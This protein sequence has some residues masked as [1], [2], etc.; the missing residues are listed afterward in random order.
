MKKMNICS[1]TRHGIHKVSSIFVNYQRMSKNVSFFFQKVLE[2]ISVENVFKIL[3]VYHKWYLYCNNFMN[4]RYSF[5][6]AGV[7]HNFEN[8]EIGKREIIYKGE[9]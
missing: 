8:G 4:I 1:P 9:G 3:V 7:W 2:I 6:L 5:L